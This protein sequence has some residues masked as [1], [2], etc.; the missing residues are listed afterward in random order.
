MATV[1]VNLRSSTFI[2]KKINYIVRSVT[3]SFTRVRNYALREKDDINIFTLGSRVIFKYLL[4]MVLL[5]SK[6]IKKWRVTGWN[7][8]V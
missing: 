7:S 2:R 1:N 4:P 3:K 8:G 5:E 6:T